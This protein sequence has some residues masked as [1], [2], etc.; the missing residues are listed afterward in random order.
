[1]GDTVAKIWIEQNGEK[2]IEVAWSELD[3][4]DE[5]EIL[6]L[7]DERWD[8]INVMIDKVFAGEK[9]NVLRIK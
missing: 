9:I 4:K 5:A 7:I 3:A 6:R 8:T 2:A 1:M